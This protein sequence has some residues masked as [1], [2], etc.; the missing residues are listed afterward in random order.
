[1]SKQTD[2]QIEVT[3]EEAARLACPVNP[4]IDIRTPLERKMGVPTGAIAMTADEVLSKYSGAGKKA[5]QGAYI[6]CAVGVSSL[7]L[8]KQLR[9]QGLKG[10]FN[11]AGGFRAWTEAGLPTGYPRG[12]SAEQAD[13]Y[14][15]HLVMPQLGPDG[16]RKLPA[17]ARRQNLMPNCNPTNGPSPRS[18]RFWLRRS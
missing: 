11:V 12:L 2:R 6:L 13:R 5:G 14:S 18:R 4:L 1:M 10:F 17:T 7:T 15:R 3:V 9:S 16:Q 8:V